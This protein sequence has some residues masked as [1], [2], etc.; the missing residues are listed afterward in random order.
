MKNPSL[1]LKNLKP[2]HFD[3]RYVFLI[4]LLLV[5]G[6][7]SFVVRDELKIV[8]QLENQPTPL[9]PRSGVRVNFEDSKFDVKR[10]ENAASFK[11]SGGL[12]N[13]PFNPAAPPPAASTSSPRTT[14][15]PS[16]ILQTP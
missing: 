5:I 2:G 4:F 10:I 12:A 14:T 8:Y 6:R 3:V 15:S 9:A 13:D 7:E 16:G 11:P 1:S